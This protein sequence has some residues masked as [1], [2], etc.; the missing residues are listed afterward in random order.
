MSKLRKFITVAIIALAAF[1]AYGLWTL[2]SPKDKDYSGFS[3]AR[4]AEDIAVISKDFHSVKEPENKIVVR[5][6]LIERLKSLGA[7]ISLY[8]YDSTYSER[9]D[10]PVDLSNIYCEFPPQNGDSTYLM[11]VAH[12][13]S[14]STN[15][16]R[17]DTL[18]SYGAADDG[19]GLGTIL[20]LLRLAQEYRNEWNQGLKI[21]IT[22]G[23]EIRMAGM[24][25]QYDNNPEVF[26]NVGLLINLEARGNKGPVLLFETSDNNR[27]LI[28]LYKE[29]A[30]YPFTYTLTSVVY[31]FIPNY[32][33]FT[34]VRDTICGINFSTIDDINHYHTDLDNYEN[35]S[36]KSIQHYGEQIAPMVHKY[37]T[38]KKYSSVDALKSDSDN[39]AFTTPLL[40][41]F[42]F[43]K[44]SY[45]LLN[46][47]FFALFC[48]AFS[49]SLIRGRVKP[50]SIL[51]SSGVIFLVGLVALVVG[52][53]VAYLVTV[54]GGSPESFKLF[55]V[56]QGFLCDGVVM[57]VTISLLVLLTILLYVK[58]GKKIAIQASS[59]SIRRSASSSATAKFA[60]NT[61]YG[62]LL[63]LLVLSAV[64]LFAIGENLFTLVPLAL[65]LCGVILWRVTTLRLFLIVSVAGILLHSF[66]FLYCLA[67]ALT[68]GAFGVVV[69]IAFFDLMVL[70]PLIDLYVRRDKAL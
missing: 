7:D 17:G 26:D 18:N 49:I 11:L 47:I 63:L 42:N 58:K 12:Y 41:M 2:P 35:I 70:I 53:L 69:M 27:E 31:K 61:L 44:G 22:D 55:G 57:I 15:I 19:Y 9:V 40:G 52:E 23:E 64:L 51:K 48:I 46:A 36:H 28:N 39:I 50:L 4:V 30:N 38:D 24:Q 66:S 21:L 6:Y 3:A 68:L 67:V 29:S 43:T 10:Y 16:V 54:I 45:Y 34:V 8:N 62:A 14:R 59:G 32:T 5:D 37:L 60:Y 33:D 25:H 56:I 13:D 1:I 65:A 20:E